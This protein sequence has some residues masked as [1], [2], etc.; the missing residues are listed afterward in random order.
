MI[1]SQPGD[2]VFVFFSDHGAA[3][4]VAM[5]SGPYL[6]ATDLMTTLNSMVANKQFNQLAF[7]LEVRL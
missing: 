3:G 5:P 1:A 7:Y 4:L 2:N 6:Y